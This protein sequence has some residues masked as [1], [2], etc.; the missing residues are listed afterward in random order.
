MVKFSL[1]HLKEKTITMSLTNHPKLNAQSLIRY[2]PECGTIG[3]VPEGKRDCCPDG[4]HSSVIPFGIAIQAYGGFVALLNK[5]KKPEEIVLNLPK[6]W[7][8]L[9]EGYTDIFHS[10]GDAAE[11]K[12]HGLSISVRKFLEAIDKRQGNPQLLITKD[13]DGSYELAV[14]TEGK[15]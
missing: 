12:A 11:W 15:S 14:G 6:G 5:G 9:N 3:D 2:C 13:K 1:T 7:R 4:S 8:L 10:I